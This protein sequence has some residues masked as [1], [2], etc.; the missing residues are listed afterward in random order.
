MQ[1]QSRSGSGVLQ[2]FHRTAWIRYALAQL[3]KVGKRREMDPSRLGSWPDFVGVAV[4]PAKCA[5]GP[6]RACSISSLQTKCVSLDNNGATLP[7]SGGGRCIRDGE[8]TVPSTTRR[9]S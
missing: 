8:R 1:A 5:V 4:K 2:A 7:R 3:N 6:R 9:P